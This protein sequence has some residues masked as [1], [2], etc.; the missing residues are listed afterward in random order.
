M[1]NAN[2][3]TEQQQLKADAWRAAANAE[4]LKK[5]GMTL[6]QA[7]AMAKMFND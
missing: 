2:G 4:Y 1:K 5:H 6:D 3:L 7:E